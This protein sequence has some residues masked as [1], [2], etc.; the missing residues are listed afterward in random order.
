MLRSRSRIFGSAVAALAASLLS[1]CLSSDSQFTV[2]SLYETVGKLANPPKPPPITLQQAA[3][4]P[5][6]SIGVR[7][8]G[9]GEQ[10][11]ILVAQDGGEMIW[12][13]GGNTLLVMHGGRLVQTG[14]LDSDLPR[15][16]AAGENLPLPIEIGNIV[17][18]RWVAD[19]TSLKRYSVT[20]TCAA[21]AMRPEV[22]TVLGKD[23]R[24]VRVDENCRSDQL[25]WSY[26]NSYWISPASGVVWESVQHF[27]PDR[28]SLTI[29]VLRPPASP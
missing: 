28:P 9:S 14:G 13:G 27:S 21:R 17:R 4:V 20:I 12:A 11:L 3:A 15:L 10:L 1:G 6:A 7:M 24:T 8:G 25:D 19:F 26:S 18:T 2:S 5:Q 22:V 16:N 23:I 29:E